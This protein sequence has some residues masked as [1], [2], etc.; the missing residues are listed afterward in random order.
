MSNNYYTLVKGKV[1][2]N[3]LP[4]EI[5][6]PRL[7]DCGHS[8]PGGWE[9][10]LECNSL[11]EPEINVWVP[12]DIMTPDWSYCGSGV[13]SVR[14][15]E[16]LNHYLNDCI[17]EDGGENLLSLAVMFREFAEKFESMSV[18][19]TDDKSIIPE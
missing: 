18:I 13:L 9:S 11:G 8:L 7:L 6:M 10:Y 17:V 4:A 1:F 19:N 14:L 5:P 15:R 16:V 12:H 3:K 2:F